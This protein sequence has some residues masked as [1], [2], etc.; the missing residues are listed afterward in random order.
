MAKRR[1]V[2][3]GRSSRSFSKGVRKTKSLNVA[4][5]GRGGYRL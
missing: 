2:A 4:R 1:P 3:K 5:P